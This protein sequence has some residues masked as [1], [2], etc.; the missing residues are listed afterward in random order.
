MI[1]GSAF[2]DGTLGNG[3]TR[4][5]LFANISTEYCVRL[6][7]VERILLNPEDV[8]Y[9]NIENGNAWTVVNAAQSLFP[10]FDCF[11]ANWWVNWNTPVVTWNNSNPTQNLGGITI[12]PG[13]SFV[14]QTDAHNTIFGIPGAPNQYPNLVGELV[15][16]WK[17][18]GSVDPV[19]V[20][21]PSALGL[22]GFGIASLRSFGR[23][24]WA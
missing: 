15:M 7:S 3:W 24:L 8:G 21:L 23:R 16:G 14:L 17:F 22:L 5:D 19:S 10:E 13:D 11:G 9:S 4:Q 18:S 2:G 20:P 12:N 1:T 6:D